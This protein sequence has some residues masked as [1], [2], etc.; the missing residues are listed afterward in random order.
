M[1]W[2]PSEKSELFESRIQEGIRFLIASPHQSC[3]DLLSYCLEKIFQATCT[4]CEEIAADPD[5]INVTAAILF[6]DCMDCD[7]AEIDCRIADLWKNDFY[8][9]MQIALVNVARN[10]PGAQVVNRWKING[11]FFQDDSRETF[12]QGVKAMLQ[13]ELWLSRK[14]LSDCIL[15]SEP[16]DIDNDC[17][18]QQLSS[19]EIDILKTLAFGASNQQIAEELSISIHTVK[20]HIYHVYKKIGV[21][22]RVQA[23]QFIA[24]VLI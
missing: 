13:G 10:K 16:S 5:G 18:L 11:I 2:H 23:S 19:R 9:D 20:T 4:W 24:E 12:A 17:K 15:L 1:C 6:I 3:F 21:S 14:M 22:N 7:N 8:E